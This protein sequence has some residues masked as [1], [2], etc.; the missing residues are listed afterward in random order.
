MQQFTVYHWLSYVTK[1]RK[2]PT[3][4]VSHE[5]D[6]Y[7]DTLLKTKQDKNRFLNSPVCQSNYFFQLDIMPIIVCANAQFCPRLKPKLDS[8]VLAY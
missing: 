8:T 6:V 7:T 1:D 5:F 2:L 4:S 3:Y